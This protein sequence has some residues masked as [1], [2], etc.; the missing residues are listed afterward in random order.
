MHQTARTKPAP[1]RRAQPPRLHR[2]HPDHA[3][4]RHAADRH[5]TRAPRPDRGGPRRPQDP[6]AL[7]V[8]AALELVRWVFALARVQ[9]ADYTEEVEAIERVAAAVEAEITGVIP[10]ALGLVD[11][12]DILTVASIL[13]TS[14]DGGDE[15][16]EAIGAAL[17][18]VTHGADAA[19]TPS[20][21]SAPRF[22]GP[23][24]GAHRVPLL[25]RHLRL[26]P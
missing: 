11:E 6:G 24:A 20:A 8:A 25:V 13:I 15:L 12:A 7:P 1:T 5:A 16:H 4:D 10:G 3:A 19:R 18:L 23:R 14:I 9:V 17:D 2:A 22:V 26:V 21:V